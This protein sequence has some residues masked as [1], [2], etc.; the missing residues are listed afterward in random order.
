LISMPGGLLWPIGAGA[1]TI[2]GRLDVVLRRAVDL[3]KWIM[4]TDR[5]KDGC[6][7]NLL[8]GRDCGMFISIPI[9]VVYRVNMRSIGTKL[10]SLESC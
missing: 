1:S 9:P 8:A 5:V 7:M 2:S 6:T 10:Q 3:R 4:F